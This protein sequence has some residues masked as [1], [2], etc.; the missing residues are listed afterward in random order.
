MATGGPAL[1]QL[2]AAAGDKQPSAASVLDAILRDN[3]ALA[4][5]PDGMEYAVDLAVPGVAIPVAGTAAG[6]RQRLIRDM[7]NLAGR[8]PTNEALAMVC[9]DAQARAWDCPGPQ[10]AVRVARN[11]AGHVV[12]DLGRPD[13]IAAVIWPGGWQLTARHGALFRHS[14]MAV[15]LPDPVP[16]GDVRPALGLVNLR[17]HDELAVYLACR[18]ASLIPRITRPV[19]IITGQPGSAKTGTTRIT[20]WWLG[21]RMIQMSRDPRDWAAIISDAHVI[22]YD[23]VSG[24]PAERADQLCRAASGDSWA[25]RGLYTNRDTDVAEYDPVSVVLNGVDAGA[26]R[27]DLVRRAVCHDLV[28][29]ERYIPEW[30]IGP[31]WEA[32]HP[33][34]LGWLC[35]LTAAVLA[36]LDGVRVP[37]AET[38]PGFA[39][40]LLAVDGM[41]GTRGYACWKAGQGN[42]YEDILEDDPVA[43]ALAAGITGPWEG[44]SSDLL[45]QVGPWLPEQDRRPWTPRR[46][47]GALDRATEALR[48]AGWQVTRPADGH[49]KSRRIVLIPPQSANG[50]S[51]GSDRI[52][53]QNMRG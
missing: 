4:Q 49:V 51:P 26:F 6:L 39:R 1:E 8:H 42:A 16:G 36:R 46:L 12:L 5:A 35:D 10:P 52:L 29:P 40:V 23:N 2:R 11:G 47:S 21:G 15:P 18:V 37:D 14:K 53:S 27:G 48:Q 44:M 38:M 19:E 25:G 43:I 22:G 17:G 24:M 3:Y 13:G 9:G 45:G 30:E 31:A 20:C 33:Q 32:A 28:K 41:W 7:R 34:A 50:H